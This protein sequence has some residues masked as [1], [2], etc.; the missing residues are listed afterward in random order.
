MSAQLSKGETDC[1]GHSRKQ[2]GGLAGTGRCGPQDSRARGHLL[3]GGRQS[4]LRCSQA[5][6][7]NYRWLG[8]LSR[9]NPGRHHGRLRQGPPPP[10]AR[11]RGPQVLTSRRPQLKRARRGCRYANELRGP[12]GSRPGGCRGGGGLARVGD[13]GLFPKRGPRDSP[14]LCPPAGWSSVTRP[15]PPAPQEKHLTG[16]PPAVRRPQCKAPRQPAGEML[17][18][19]AQ[20]QG[21]GWG[22]EAGGGIG[23]G[24][25]GLARAFLLPGQWPG[26]STYRQRM[27]WCPAGA[28]H[29]VGLRHRGYTLFAFH[30]KG[31]AV[32]W[33][34]GLRGRRLQGPARQALQP[35]LAREQGGRIKGICQ[36][37]LRPARGATQTRKGGLG[38]RGEVWGARWALQTPPSQ[39]LRSLRSQAGLWLMESEAWCRLAQPGAGWRALS[40]TGC[41]WAA[42]SGL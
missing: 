18:Q 17:R 13:L 10:A 36:K 26:D 3:R 40:Q 19:D 2:G 34:R 39:G 1:R 14:N 32:A 20:V 33:G 38:G 27:S 21:R 11:A 8:P 7:F 12:L 42:M 6:S 23:R 15:T 37:L 9:T 29:L 35:W 41:W 4:P 16:K 28:R 30:S 22:P 31:Q 25:S 24:V 5:G